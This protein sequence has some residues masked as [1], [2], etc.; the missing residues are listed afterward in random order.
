[1]GELFARYPDQTWG[2]TGNGRAAQERVMLAAARA[3]P[4]DFVALD[5]APEL[6]S[7]EPIIIVIRCNA[8]DDFSKW[9]ATRE[10]LPALLPT[11]RFDE[12]GRRVLC[13]PSTGRAWHQQ[14]R[15]LCMGKGLVACKLT[16]FQA[17]HTYAC[18]A[19]NARTRASCSM[20]ARAR[21]RLG[22]RAA[23]TQPHTRTAHTQG[24]HEHDASERTYNVCVGRQRERLERRRGIARVRGA[25]RSHIV[26]RSSVVARDCG[27]GHGV[28]LRRCIVACWCGCVTAQHARRVRGR[29]AT[30]AQSACAC[31]ARA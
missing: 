23:H 26:V 12:E 1:M 24:T 17:C 16:S 19:C 29:V 11:P 7:D 5:L 30:R 21:V 18:T 4:D 31:S 15:A 14:A 28:R 25:A 27:V 20:R 8:L 13:E 10:T 2:P 3:N 9:V 6:G 22:A